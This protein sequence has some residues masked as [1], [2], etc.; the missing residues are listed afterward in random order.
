MSPYD[1]PGAWMVGGWVQG[2][3]SGHS[4]VAKN[5]GVR[6]TQPGPILAPPFRQWDPGPVIQPLCT[7]LLTCK[8][9][10]NKSP[11]LMG[12]RGGCQNTSF[13]FIEQDAI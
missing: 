3:G 2:E 4:I 11:H 12:L 1:L 5:V 9:G 6:A 8:V 10:T 7:C 13:E